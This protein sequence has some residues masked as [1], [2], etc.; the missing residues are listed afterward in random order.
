MFL[1]NVLKD[2]F[3]NYK[4]VYELAEE[5]G[6]K[7]S[8]V[9]RQKAVLGVKTVEVRNEEGEQIWLWFIPKNVWKKY[10]QTQ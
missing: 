3:V 9:K 7:K 6:M 5:S 1:E 10:S 4:R 8:E 2:G